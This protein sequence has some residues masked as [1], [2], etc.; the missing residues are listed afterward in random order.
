MLRCYWFCVSQIEGIVAEFAGKYDVVVHDDDVL[1]EKK[2]YK[3]EERDIIFFKTK[4]KNILYF[5][6][7]YVFNI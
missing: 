2:M 1:I 5:L 3:E 4:R 6:N 7:I